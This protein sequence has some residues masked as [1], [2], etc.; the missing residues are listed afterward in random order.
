[1]SSGS[2]RI[3]QQSKGT[4]VSVRNEVVVDDKHA[5]L[6]SG[7]DKLDIT[8]VINGLWQ[9]SG[10]WGKI[11]RDPAVAAMMRHVDAGLTTFDMADHSHRKVHSS[12]TRADKV[13]GQMPQIK[14]GRRGRK[15]TETLKSTRSTTETAE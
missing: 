2:K 8:R 12:L 1:M 5:L 6:Q 14:G 11:E 9:T 10:G 13:S 7:S 4:S 3:T 15:L